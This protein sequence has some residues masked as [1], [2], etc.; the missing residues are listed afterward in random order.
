MKIHYKASWKAEIEISIN[1]LFDVKG[2]CLFARFMPEGIAEESLLFHIKIEHLTWMSPR[3][4][5]SE[6]RVFGEEIVTNFGVPWQPN[7]ITSRIV[8]CRQGR[9]YRAVE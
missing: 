7:S 3:M 1:K 2:G 8:N 4:D 9:Q 6:L 5:V